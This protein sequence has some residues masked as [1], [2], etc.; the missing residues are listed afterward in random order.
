MIQLFTMDSET[1][2]NAYADGE[3]SEPPSPKFGFSTASVVKQIILRQLDDYS[4]SIA[5]DAFLLQDSAV[6]GR[7]RIAIEVRLGEKEILASALQSVEEKLRSP[8]V[9]SSTCSASNGDADDFRS[10]RK[11]M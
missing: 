8:S 10:K 11:K 5:E 7:R 6:Q 9:E 2:Q 1:L 4:T 3:A